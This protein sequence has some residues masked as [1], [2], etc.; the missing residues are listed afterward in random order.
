MAGDSSRGSSTSDLSN[1]A[2]TALAPH[3]GGSTSNVPGSSAAPTTND[4]R[5]TSMLPGIT[6]TNDVGITGTGSLDNNPTTPKDNPTSTNLETTIQTGSAH[7]GAGVV[8][9]A[10]ISRDILYP[11]LGSRFDTRLITL[12]RPNNA[13]LIQCTSQPIALRDV[14]DSEV[15]K[16][17]YEA[18]KMLLNQKMSPVWADSL[19]IDQDNDEDKGQQVAKMHVIYPHATR[20]FAWLGPA[21]S[22]H[23]GSDGELGLS[24]LKNLPKDRTELVAW[25]HKEIFAEQQKAVASL[26][27]RE[28]W[29]R[30]WIIQGLSKARKVRILCGNQIADLKVF[31]DNLFD[32]NSLLKDTLVPNATREHF[33]CLR[34]FHEQE[35]TVDHRCHLS[36]P[37]FSVDTLK[38]A[39]HE[40]RSTL[41]RI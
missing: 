6:I 22:D 34:Q 24:T 4:Q 8:A 7:G 27:N 17:L 35:Q 12:S 1:T 3:I 25:A 13:G 41:S 18:L 10:S 20:V 30:S 19:S 26:V 37:S 40:I 15:R 14:P 11:P 5:D 32:L 9:D 16:T 39:C 29:K 36:Q 31:L 2:N 33:A 23:D 21:K 28:Y 38:L